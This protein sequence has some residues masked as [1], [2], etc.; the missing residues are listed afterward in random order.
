MRHSSL[1]YRNALC[2]VLQTFACL[3]FRIP[4]VTLLSASFLASILNPV[5]ATPQ[6]DEATSRLETAA[7]LTNLET[8]D[9]TPYCLQAQ[10]RFFSK[11]SHR[12]NTGLFKSCFRS[13]SSWR[14]EIEWPDKT[15]IEMVEG[16]HVWRNDV[17]QRRLDILRM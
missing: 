6:S 12:P 10:L 9:V 5:I 13:T 16:D 8:D 11:S 15:S 7:R 1:V 4:V 3:V 17:D 2:C 14:D